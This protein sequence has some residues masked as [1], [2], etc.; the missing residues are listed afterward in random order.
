MA[1]YKCIV[2][3]YI[4]DESVGDEEHKVKKGTLFSDLPEDWVCPVCGAPKNMFKRIE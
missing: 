4:Y 3:D 2:C 1:K